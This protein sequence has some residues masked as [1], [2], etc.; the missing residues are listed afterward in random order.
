[1]N[2][3]VKLWVLIAGFCSPVLAIAH[4][5]GRMGGTMMGGYMMPGMGIMG[6]LVWTLVV[7][8]LVL[9]IMACIKYLKNK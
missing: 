1:M 5:S 7:V 8:L 3:L 2:Y 6:I 9:G 4:E